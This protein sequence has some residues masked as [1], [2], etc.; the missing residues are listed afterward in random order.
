[1][2]NAGETASLGAFYDPA[3]AGPGVKIVEVIAGGPLDKAGL[4]IAPGTV[5]EAIDGEPIAADRDL[6]HYLNRKAGKNV[7][8]AL[9][10]PAPAGTAKGA[11]APVKRDIAV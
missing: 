4:D 6:E 11:A 3:H 5:I 8:L 2:E 9:T 10:S 1:M 7:L